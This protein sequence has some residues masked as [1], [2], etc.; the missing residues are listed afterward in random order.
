MAYP[1]DQEKW[2]RAR[3][4]LDRNDL[5]AIVVRAPD[6]VLYLTNYWTMTG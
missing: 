2:R 5:D 3:A 4:M 6:N 1:L